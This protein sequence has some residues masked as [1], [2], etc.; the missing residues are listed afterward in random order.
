M[1]QASSP[2]VKS[3]SHH[4]FIWAYTMKLWLKYLLP[5]GCLLS[6]IWIPASEKSLTQEPQDVNMCPHPWCFL[7]GASHGKTAF[8]IHD[9]S[10]PFEIEVLIGCP[11]KSEETQ[12]LD[13]VSKRHCVNGLSYSATGFG[14]GE[15]AEKQRTLILSR[16]WGKQETGSLSRTCRGNSILDLHTG[17]HTLGHPLSELEGRG[18]SAP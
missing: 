18:V 10:M 4:T 3:P 15:L 14:D 1:V 13:K 12:T 2:T 8:F 6:E 17:K 9:W 11:A 5:L 16:I 7:Y